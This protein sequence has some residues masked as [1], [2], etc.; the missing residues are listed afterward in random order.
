MQRFSI[1]TKP[2]YF[3]AFDVKFFWIIKNEITE[4]FQPKLNELTKFWATE[5]LLLSPTNEQTETD[6]I[7]FQLKPILYVHW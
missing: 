5:T 6:K 4:M 2:F 7:K 1:S 3:S